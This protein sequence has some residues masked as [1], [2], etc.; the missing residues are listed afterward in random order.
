MAGKARPKNLLANRTASVS[1]HR[2]GLSVEIQSVP[3]TDA[4]IVSQ[5]LLDMMRNLI[6]AGY[7]ELVADAG[8][9]HGGGHDV[10][11]EVDGD[12]YVIQPHAKRAIGF[13]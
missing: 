13:R 9:F 1:V 2:N 10:P 7:D 8:S 11:D 12:D 3:A 4:G 5:A 6:A